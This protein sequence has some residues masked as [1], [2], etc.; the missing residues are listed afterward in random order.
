MDRPLLRKRVCGLCIN[1]SI[2]KRL[3]RQS[4]PEPERRWV[5][6]RCTRLM[7]LLEPASD[8]VLH[9]ARNLSGLV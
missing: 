6:F 7:Q 4:A 5:S 2:L 3:P 1:V 8:P 9:L